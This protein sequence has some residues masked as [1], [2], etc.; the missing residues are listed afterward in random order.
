MV[1]IDFIKEIFLSVKREIIT[2]NSLGNG[3]NIILSQSW[4]A[5]FSL[6]DELEINQ[7]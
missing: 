6:K 1:Q 2:S 3:K 7:A 5:A 4:A